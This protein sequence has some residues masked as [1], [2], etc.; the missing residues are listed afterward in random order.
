M[1][2]DLRKGYDMVSWEFVEKMLKGYGFAEK[3]RKLIIN[4]IISIKFSVRINGKSYEYFAG[5]KGL[6]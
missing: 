3:F 6:R 1:Q 4:C 5:Q 2:I